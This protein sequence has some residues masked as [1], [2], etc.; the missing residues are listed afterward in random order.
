MVLSGRLVALAALGVLLAAWSVGAVLSYAALLA[1]L[2]LVDLALAGRIAAL[3]LSREPS[4]SVRLRERGETVLLIANPARRA[5]RATVRDAW[6]PSA[7]AA[8]RSQSVT[9]PA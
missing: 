3:R 8:P 6:V 5:L 2:T 9:V 1:A 7:G 4:A